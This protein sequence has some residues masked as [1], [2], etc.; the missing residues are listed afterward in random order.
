MKI[1]VDVMGGDFFPQAPIEGAILAKSELPTDCEI[2]L[3]GQKDII[4]NELERQGVQKNTFEIV[5]ASEI[6]GMSEHPTKAATQKKDSSINVGIKLARIG[7]LDAFISAGNTG[8]MLVSSVFGLKNIE[9][10]IRPTIGTN[11]PY[12]DHFS[13]ISDVGANTDCKP[14][15]LNQF[16]LLSSIYS[17]EVMK[18]ENPRVALLSI[19]EEESKGDQLTIAA[20][21]LL[22]ENSK[23]N[24]IGNKEGR[25]IN[26][27]D[28]DIY[29]CDGFVGNIILKFTESFFDVLKH[30]LGGNTDQIQE[31]NYE[32]YGGIP[33]LGI[34][35]VSIIGHGMSSPRAYKSM[36]F[37]AKEMVDAKLVEKIKQSLN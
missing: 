36:I 11:L 18:V 35:G 25:D 26:S 27:T 15:F 19:G 20:H 12:R 5:H 16:A 1:G 30:K 9:G 24:F 10:V 13:F 17:K 6:I 28:V 33:I 37:K 29:I 21:K 23:I 34:E 4:E 3:V 14:E 22:R 8:A 2:V 32:T 31:Y 7:E